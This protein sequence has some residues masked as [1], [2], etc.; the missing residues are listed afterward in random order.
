MIDIFSLILCLVISYSAFRHGFL[1]EFLKL[2]GLFVSTILAFQFYPFLSGFLK[3]RIAFLPKQ[4][5]DFIACSVIFFSVSIVFYLL[6]K[7]VGIFIKAQE[8]SAYQ[9]CA[10]LM[11]G[12]VRLVLLIST[13]LFLVSLF[14]G[15]F[16]LAQSM[17]Y[18]LCKHAA[19]GVY[20]GSFKLYNTCIPNAIVLNG[21]VKKYYEVQGDVSGDSQKRT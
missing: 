3:E 1:I 15:K 7:F 21:E 2:I 12:G 17:S 11:I 4:F 19:P 20:L 6:G 5:L 8:L 13:L 9:R 14:P 18:R 10:A 16:T